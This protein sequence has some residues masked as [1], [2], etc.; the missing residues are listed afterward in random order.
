MQG[1]E[2]GGVFLAGLISF[3]TPCIL[4]V[5]PVFIS[6]LLGG[7][8]G[9]Q[10]ENTGRFRRALKPV[11]RVTMFVLGLSISFMILGL[12]FGALG[13]LIK[14]SAFQIT[15]GIIVILLG[16]YQTGIVKIPFLMREKKLNAGTEKKG[17]LSSFLLGFTFSFG[18]TPCIGPILA[19]VLALTASSGGAFIGVF[20]MA[21]YSLGL[22]IP[23]LAFAVFSD[24]LVSRIKMLYRHLNTIKIAGGIVIIIMGVLLLTGN[25]NIFR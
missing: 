15:C 18:W 20:Y 16:I 2:I 3:F 5:I 14:S 7:I 4:P 25:L 9:D 1:I 21:I 11:L 22:L 8:D 23:F 6:N 24:L 10:A 13:R 19:G 17:L 12:A